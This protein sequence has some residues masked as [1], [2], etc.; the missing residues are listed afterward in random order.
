MAKKRVKKELAIGVAIAIVILL[1]FLIFYTF[2]YVKSVSSMEEFNQQLFNCNRASFVSEQT[3]AVWGYEI[4]GKTKGICEVDVKL[5]SAKEGDS[6]IKS[7]EGKDMI[8]S[9]PLG[10]TANPEANLEVCHGLLKEEIQ[11]VMIRNCHSQI[12]ANIG[13]INEELESV[14]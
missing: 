2:F 13:E 12:L 11:E 9:M 8:C 4:L 1:S 7:L 14:F 10:S 3:T 6:D 5:I